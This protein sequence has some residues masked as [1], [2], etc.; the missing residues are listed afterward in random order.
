MLAKFRAWMDQRKKTRAEAE[1]L[2]GQRWAHDEII[3]GRGY[4]FVVDCTYG[5]LAPYDR[6]AHEAIVA[7]RQVRSTLGLPDY[8]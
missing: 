2:E 6:G 5:H 3:F 1:F 8:P 4:A 7:H